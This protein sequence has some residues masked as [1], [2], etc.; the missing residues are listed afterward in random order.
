[1][2][3][4]RPDRHEAI[5]QLLYQGCRLDSNRRVAGAV[6]MADA[7]IL[8]RIGRYQARACPQDRKRRPTPLPGTSNPRP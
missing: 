3:S 6:R 5:H 7:R 4:L 2:A 1:M 8:I